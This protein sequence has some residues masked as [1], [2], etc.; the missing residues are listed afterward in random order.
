MRGQYLSRQICFVGKCIEKLM[1]RNDVTV[2]Q[3]FLCFDGYINS[4]GGFGE[5]KYL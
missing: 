1:H 4:K 2:T 3:K 5:T